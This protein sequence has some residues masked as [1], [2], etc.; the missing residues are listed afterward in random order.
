HLTHWVG[1]G[2]A[3][4]PAP[5]LKLRVYRD[6]RL[7]EAIYCDASSRYAALAGVPHID[8]Q[9]LATQWPRNCLLNSWLATCLQQGHGFSTAQRPRLTDSVNPVD[10]VPDT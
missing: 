10:L 1:E 3:A 8:D 7:A 4:R 6:A 9:V 2:V 5:D